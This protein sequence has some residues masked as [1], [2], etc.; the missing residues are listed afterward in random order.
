MT[1]GFLPH[2]F[3]NF[4]SFVHIFPCIEFTYDACTIIDR[5]YLLNKIFKKIKLKKYREFS[6]REM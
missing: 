5:K 6:T 3:H 1:S 2:V 4:M